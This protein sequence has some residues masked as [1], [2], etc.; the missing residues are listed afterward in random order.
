MFFPTTR[1]SDSREGTLTANGFFHFLLSFFTCA[2][3]TM[4]P[5]G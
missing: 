5:N 2:G 1:R 4:D 3:G